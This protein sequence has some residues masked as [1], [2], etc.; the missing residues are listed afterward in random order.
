MLTAGWSSLNAEAG[1]DAEDHAACSET[2]E[3]KK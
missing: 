2:G 1:E 3:E